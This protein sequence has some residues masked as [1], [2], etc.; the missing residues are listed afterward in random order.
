MESLQRKRQYKE[1]WILWIPWLPRR[2]LRK[3]AIIILASSLAF[4]LMLLANVV[5]NFLRVI[6]SR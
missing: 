2:E 5:I 1:K 3:I 6:P 4:G